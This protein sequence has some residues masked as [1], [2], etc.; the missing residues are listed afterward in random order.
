MHTDVLERRFAAIGA[1]MKVIRDTRVDSVQIDVSSD[2]RGEFFEL[3]LDGRRASLEVV[4][5]DKDE[6]C[7]L[8]LVRDRDDK[9]KFL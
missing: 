6:R 8:L 9:S 3:R 1:R 4:E 7:L 2:R 5:A